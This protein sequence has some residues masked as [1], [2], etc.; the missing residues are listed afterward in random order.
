MEKKV[1][2][3][4]YE[5]RKANKNLS[6]TNL[7]LAA[8]SITDGLTQIAN[9]RHFD[10]IMSQ[11]YTRHIRSRANLSL[12]LL[13]IDHFKAFNDNYGHVNGDECLRQVARVIADCAAR[14]ADLAARYGGEEFACI[15]PE[16]D[17]N[18]A[19]AVAEN[20]RIGVMALKIPHKAS[21]VA[22]YVTVSLGVITVQCSENISAV[23]IVAKVDD[24][25]YRAKSSGRNKVEFTV[26]INELL[27]SVGEIHGRLIN[28]VWQETFYSGNNIIDSQHKVLFQNFNELLEKALSVR[29]F[30][31]N[32]TPTENSIKIDILEMITRLIDDIKQHFHDEESI[33]ETAGFPEL[34]QHAAEHARLMAKSLELS[35]DFKNSTLSVGDI[36]QFFAY[37]VISLHM[38]SA[39]QAFFPFLSNTKGKT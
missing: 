18:G 1:E 38:F 8:I 21:K 11:E 30:S 24:A 29:P 14:P 15:L 33:L 16:T 31:K 27:P 3:R 4:T 7:K 13:D 22:E 17:S 36:F 12:I 39:D 20:I 37:E 34:K 19:V 28:L 10:E 26:I 25:L 5:L 2:E 35:Q 23:E 32:L 6:E 9:R